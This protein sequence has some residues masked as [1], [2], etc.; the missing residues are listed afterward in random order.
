[1]YTYECG[2]HRENAVIWIR[3]AYDRSAIQEIKKLEGA[4]WS[5]T[6]QSWYVPDTAAYREQFGIDGLSGATP[7]FPDGK[8]RKQQVEKIWQYPKTG[9]QKT[10]RSK[11]IDPVNS[12][13]LPALQQRL[14]LGGYSA[15]TIRTYMNEVGV[16]LRTIGAHAADEFTTDRLKDYFTYCL[17]RL[18]LSEHTLHSR[19]NALKFYYEQV[20][21]REQFYW[22][23]PRP[24]KGFQLPRVLS[25]EEV[26]KLLRCIYNQKHKAMVMLAYACG[27]RVSEI[28]ALELQDLDENRRLLFIKRGKG[29][30]DRVVSL[31]GV[32]LVMLREYM[33]TYKPARYLFEGKEKGSIYSIRSLE[34]VMTI[35]KQRAGIRKKG[36]MHLLRHSF[37]THLL[38]KGTDVV[39]IQKLLGHNTI[40]TT[41]RYLHVT[42]KDLLQV[43][44]PI[45]DIK[46]FL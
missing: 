38:D 11:P 40:K 4:R 15:S 42:N 27:L 45:E 28:T 19:L 41:L 32:I 44:S 20:L 29:K 12:H 35:A 8:E 5:A 34:E 2:W 9:V 3:F 26:I 36:N 43:L 22:D 31:S 37:A 23:I 16:F 7:A 13:I 25:K 33:R 17:D 14:I 6:Q 24:K 46:D 39:F 18:K 1:M 10:P 21:A 30:K